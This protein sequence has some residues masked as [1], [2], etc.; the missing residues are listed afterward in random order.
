MNGVGRRHKRED[1]KE[2]GQPVAASRKTLRWDEDRRRE[3]RLAKYVQQHLV[4]WKP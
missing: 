4:R 2:N 3:Y 1:A